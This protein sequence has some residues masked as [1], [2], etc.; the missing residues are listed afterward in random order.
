VVDTL[1]LETSFLV[2]LERE[3]VAGEPGP[4]HR[5]LEAHENHQLLITFTVAGELAI[6]PK[7][8]ERGTWEAL[9]SPFEVLACTP[10]VCWRYG[11]LYR[12]LKSNGL[13]IGANDLWIAATAVASDMP[14]VTRDEQHFARVPGLAVIGYD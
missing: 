6:G 8:N 1:V 2:D 3:V 9:V 10:D 5:F 14:L 7:L 11:R 12:Y 13:L 4:A